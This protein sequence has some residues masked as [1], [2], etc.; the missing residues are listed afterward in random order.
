MKME[1]KRETHI[2]D[3]ADK[4]LGRLAV[5]VAVLLRGK[6]KKGFVPN[7]DIGDFVDIKNVKKIKFSG[8]KI[9]QKKYFHHSGYLGGVR[10]VPLKDLF[11]KNPKEVLRTAVYGMLPCNK[12]RDEQIKRLRFI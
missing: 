7:L 9:N 8:N 12:L 11:E 3:V 1:T 10:M 4:I 5:Q 2:I 6:N